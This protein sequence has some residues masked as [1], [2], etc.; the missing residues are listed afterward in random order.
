MNI[1]ILIRQNSD[2]ETIFTYIL[3]VN[4]VL[5]LCSRIFIGNIY[6]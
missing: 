6:I 1:L 5:W 3:L 4:E 2:F